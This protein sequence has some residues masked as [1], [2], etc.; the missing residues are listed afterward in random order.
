MW[1]VRG[2]EVMVLWGNL[3]EREYLKGL[4]VERSIILK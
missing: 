4:G 1:H 2:R 3:R